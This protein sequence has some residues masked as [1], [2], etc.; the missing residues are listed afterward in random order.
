MPTAPILPTRIKLLQAH[1]KCLRRA[2][3]RIRLGWRLRSYHG[4]NL[5]NFHYQRPLIQHIAKC[6]GLRGMHAYAEALMR[7]REMRSKVNLEL[8]GHNAAG[9][10]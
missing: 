8:V 5:D 2:E 7:L 6:I 3:R 1:D 4:V 9:K 10:A